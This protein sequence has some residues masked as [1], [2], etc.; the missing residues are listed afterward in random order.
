MKGGSI[1]RKRDTRKWNE[2]A[3]GEAQTARSEKAERVGGHRKGLPREAPCKAPAGVQG[4][5]GQRS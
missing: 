2:A 4:V 3:S 5:S 1:M